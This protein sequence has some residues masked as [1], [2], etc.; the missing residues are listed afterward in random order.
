MKA[1]WSFWTKPYFAGRGQGWCSNWHTE[2]HHWLAWGLSVYAAASLSGNQSRYRRRRRAHSRRRAP[3][4]IRQRVHCAEPAQGRRSAMVVAWQDRGLPA[5]AVALRAHR[6]RCF[7]MAAASSGDRPGGCIHAKPRVHRARRILLPPCRTRGMPP[8]FLA[9][10]AAPGVVR[11]RDRGHMRRLLWHFRRAPSGLYSA[12]RGFRDARGDRSGQP[13]RLAIAAGK[14]GH[15]ILVEQYLLTACRQFHGV[16]MRYLF[17]TI[18]EAYCC[19]APLRPDSR[20]LRRAPKA[21]P[22]SARIW[23]SGCSGIF[24][25][26]S[27]IDAGDGCKGSGR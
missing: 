10:V 14:H 2:W 9:H 12:L 19:G 5:P 23:M 20:I 6:C 4:S 24:R 26:Y 22:P 13:P 1:V 21:T 27:T 11:L 16:P 18:E 3:T 7:S 25:R 15:M 17:D 8:R